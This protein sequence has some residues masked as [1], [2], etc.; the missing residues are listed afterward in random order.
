MADDHDRDELAQLR[1]ELALQQVRITG[2]LAERRRP[3]RYPP[4]R[5]L[6]LALAA[7]LV[8][9]LPLATFA[10]GFT[11]LN[12][13]SP[14]NDNIAAIAAVGV[15]KGCNPPDWY[16]QLEDALGGEDGTKA[17]QSQDGCADQARTDM[18]VTTRQVAKRSAL[19]WR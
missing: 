9:L 18:P 15:T 19:V 16:C 17:G 8:A 14:H 5:V 13:G 12:T 11:D 2:L 3:G 1:A 6:P 7:L 10:A 4:R